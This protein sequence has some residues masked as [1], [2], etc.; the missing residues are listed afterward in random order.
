MVDIIH[1]RVVKLDL[2]N[3]ILETKLNGIM[4]EEIWW[5]RNKN[6]LYVCIWQEKNTKC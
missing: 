1:V 5:K 2:W 3:W 6:N 4:A